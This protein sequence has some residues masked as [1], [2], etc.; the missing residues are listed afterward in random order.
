M[1]RFFTAII[2]ELLYVLF[3]KVIIINNQL[4][5]CFTLH[6]AL[7]THTHTHT[8]T[9]TH[10]NKDWINMQPLDRTDSVNDVF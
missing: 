4:K 2:R 7:H 9:Y 6:S 8:H 1:Y 3:A 5:Y 10:T